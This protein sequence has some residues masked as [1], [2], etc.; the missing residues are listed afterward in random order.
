MSDATDTPPADDIPRHAR[1]DVIGGA[2][3]MLIAGLVWY[4]AIELDVG[5]LTRLGSGAMPKAIA[6]LLSIAGGGLLANGLMRRSGE[7][8]RFEF[9]LRPS[10][11]I[12]AAMLIFGLFI[13]GGDF[14]IFST[15][16]LGLTVVGPLTVIIA[17]CAAPNARFGELVVTAFG[18]T[19][20]L[21]LVFAD[22][23]GV[24]V[25]VFPDFL[26]AAIP[27][28]IDTATRLAY[29]VYGAL[30]AALYVLIFRWGAQRD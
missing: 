27:L 1:V 4:G 10:V 18:L 2:V 13:R 26:E 29:C 16:R 7:S 23:L 5:R 8:E 11:I 3:I 28:G 21:L 22:L 24:P 12:V 9:T 20:G 6:L 14:G 25:P 15:P 30:A 19:A 17:G